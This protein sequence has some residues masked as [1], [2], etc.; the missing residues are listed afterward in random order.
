[1][2]LLADAHRRLGLVAAYAERLLQQA[3]AHDREGDMPYVE[4]RAVGSEL[5]AILET[6]ASGGVRVRDRS[7]LELAFWSRSY[8][9]ELGAEVLTQLLLSELVNLY[10]DQ[11]KSESE[12]VAAMQHGFGS[13]K[14]AREALDL[15][16]GDRSEG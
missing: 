13:V 11:G 16:S 4:Q 7:M 15:P 14:A 8:A 1:M 3:A 9:G 2:N 5:A 6:G 12:F 10:L